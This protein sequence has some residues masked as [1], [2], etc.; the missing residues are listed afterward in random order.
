[1]VLGGRVG[2]YECGALLWGGSGAGHVSHKRK[3]M[4]AKVSVRPPHWISPHSS[5]RGHGWATNSSRMNTVCTP[6][7]NCTTPNCLCG[8]LSAPTLPG[9]WARSPL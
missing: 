6:Y 3:P 5:S 4:A 9:L 7:E 8:A 1:M 2:C